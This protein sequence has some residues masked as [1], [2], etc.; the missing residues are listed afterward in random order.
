MAKIE[1]TNYEDALAQSMDF[2]CIGAENNTDGH[3]LHT[4]FGEVTIDGIK[5]Q[6]QISFIADAREWMN[7]YEVVS[8]ENT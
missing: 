4:A 3:D 7:G 5:Y 2:L 1:T 8:I 6:M